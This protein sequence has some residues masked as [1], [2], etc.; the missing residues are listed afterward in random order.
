MKWR[1]PGVRTPIITSILALLASLLVGLGTAAP[2]Q[3]AVA[4]YPVPTSAANLGRIVPHPDGSLWFVEQD[5]NKVGR[6]TTA[7]QI[8]EYPLPAPTSVGN[9]VKD[10]DIAADGTVWV[11]YDQGRQAIALNPDGSTKLGPVALGGEPNGEQIRVAAEGTPW[12]TIS[13]SQDLI[14][15]IADG[16]AQVSSNSPPCDGAL[17]IGNDGNKWCQD[18]DKVIKVNPAGDGGVTIPLPPNASYPYSLSP[19]PLGSIWYARHSGATWL[20]S[21][22]RGSIGYL[23]AAGTVTDI[24]TGSRTAPASLTQ[25]GGRMWFTNVGREP[26]IGHYDVAT[27]EGAISKV[28]NYSPGWATPGSDGAIWA[29]DAKNNVILR[30]PVDELM[31]TNIDLGTGSV[32]KPHPTAGDQVGTITAGSKPLRVRKRV[33]KL[34]ATCP[35]GS[36]SCRGTARIRV[37][38]KVIARSRSYEIRPG[39]RTLIK[40]RITKQG[41][42][43]VRRKPTKAIA[44][45]LAPGAK[46]PSATKKIRLRR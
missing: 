12:I 6:I 5:A 26:G 38:K 17:G 1:G 29:T 46:R 40:L 30:V 25:A 45:L 15:W 13:F 9:V 22:D 34:P 19:G 39:S 10:L 33:V 43:K 44:Q 18:F 21:P 8:T 23:D 35:S 16:Q 36:E 4:V 14:A 2:A 24:N 20:T 11:V 3:A 27:G 31:I 42:R 7:G 32:L 37:G 28:G 41:L